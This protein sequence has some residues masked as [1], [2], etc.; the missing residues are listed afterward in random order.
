L[1]PSLRDLS[2]HVELNCFKFSRARQ[3][4]V[5]HPAGL[6]QQ[7]LQIRVNGRRNSIGRKRLV[8]QIPVERPPSRPDEETFATIVMNFR[9]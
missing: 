2:I 5:L 9:F 8:E 4:T 1:I 7:A 3:K 6:D